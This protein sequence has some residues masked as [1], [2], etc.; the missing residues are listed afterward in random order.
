MFTVLRKLDLHVNGDIGCYTLAALPPYSAMHTQGCMGAGIGMHLGMEKAHG[1]EMARKS[2]A[3]IGDSTFVH[4]GHHAAHRPGV[5]PGAPARSS[6]W[7]TAGTAMTGHQ[8][9]PAT[10]RTLMGEETHAL[11]LELLVKALGVKRVV[12]TDP[13]DMDEFERIV[14][15]EVAAPGAVGHHS[16]EKMHPDR[17]EGTGHEER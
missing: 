17:S 16:A 3:V 8:D 10:G 12:V 13:K 7:T 9:H 4:S 6:S 1:A 15:E 5:Q 11:D 14:R 2:V